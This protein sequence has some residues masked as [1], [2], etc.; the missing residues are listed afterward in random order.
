MKLNSSLNKH[1]LRFQSFLVAIIV[2]DAE[3]IEAW[4]KKIEV[5]GDVTKLCQDEV[6]KFTEGLRG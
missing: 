3:L 5:E 1:I 2:P 4:A 6:N